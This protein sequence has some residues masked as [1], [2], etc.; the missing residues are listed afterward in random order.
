M[1]NLKK[2]LALVLALVM[3]FSLMATAN[4]FTDS[5]KINGT[6]EE[7][8]EVLSGLKVFQGYDNGSFV[9]Q[10]SITRAEVAAIIY[11]IVTGDV[12]DKQVGIYADYNKFND[13]KSTS[14]YAGYVNFCA[15]AEYIK[16]YDAKTFGP[17]DP[18]T[19]YQALAMIL[20]AVGYD[21]NGEFTGTGWQ[22]QT[23]AVGKKLGITNNV[24][25]GTLGVAATREV[26]AEILF[27]S[28]L[29]P[30]VEYTVAFGYQSIGQVSIGYETFKL[31][32]F[33]SGSDV[34]G[35]PAKVWKLDADNDRVAESTDVTLVSLAYEP[36]AT[37]TVKEDEC[38]IAKDLGISVATK[39]EKAFIDGVEYLTTDADVTTNRYGTINPLA[40]TSYVGAQG[41]L[42]EIYDMGTAGYRIVEINTYLA[43]VS[44]VVAE[45]V[46]KSGHV[47]PAYIG[48]NVYADS[49]PAAANDGTVYKTFNTTGFN[50]GDY[51]LVTMTGNA[52][53]NYVVRSVEAAPMGTAGALMGWTNGAGT[54]PDT[55]TIGATTLNDADK[56]DCNWRV[57]GNWVPALDTYGNV[58]GLVHPVTNYLVV[59]AIEWQHAGLYQGH[60]T[61]NV[62]LADGSRVENVT[63]ASVNGFA[64]T[65]AGDTFGNPVNATVSDNYVNNGN[66]RQ[67]DLYYNHIFTYTVNADGSYSIANNNHA[68]QIVGNI[69]DLANATVV[70]G[71]ATIS[72]ATNTVVATDNTVFLVKNL[73]GTN[74]GYTYTTYVGKNNVPSLTNADICVL[75]DAN[76]YATLVVVSNYE[77]AANTFLAYV[78]EPNQTG[79]TT[80]LGRAYQVYKIGE[81]TAT[82][83]YDVVA[84]NFWQYSNEHGTGLY[85]FTV[86]ANNQIVAMDIQVCDLHCTSSYTAYANWDRSAVKAGI[87]AG[88]F[89]TEGYNAVAVD[90]TKDNGYTV[91][92]NNTAIKDYVV[93]TDTKYFVVTKTGLNSTAIVTE[94]TTAD[95]TA[96]S[97]VL[98]NYTTLGNGNL[99][100]NM[101]YVLRV[102]AD[103]QNPNPNPVNASLT[104]TR[105]A[106][107]VFT[108]TLKQGTTAIAGA[109]TY[110]QVSL[111]G[112]AYSTPEEMAYVDGSYNDAAKTWQFSGTV[113]LV[114]SGNYTIRV[115]SVV[116]TQEIASTTYTIVQ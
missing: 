30:Q 69:R 98:V 99:V 113:N 41:R 107:N 100:A 4:A 26:V 27:R 58:I 21:K 68:A 6:Y 17:N 25:E 40:T 5:D 92:T 51:V 38:D 77:L 62:M 115:Y 35:R 52:A 10:G 90:L 57:G 1:R 79:F 9:P 45:T 18:V 81:T 111:N 13:V 14:W 104:L 43:Q 59:E 95:V 86:N 2:I 44:K 63:V 46:D 37:Y 15:N 97:V 88:S 112:G 54:N 109:K 78:T 56:F 67:G 89:Q 28:I 39:I 105:G 36:A 23:A 22:T 103:G 7:A 108:A 110:V 55:T 70:N 76:G 34:W 24:S 94:G 42:T 12:T 83:V 116:G 106:N 47:T 65:N 71:R 31:V 80:A 33:V 48:V 87:L 3:S 93:T 19:G 72:N 61:A 8:V 50:V 96:G 66:N 16:G 101:V 114:G 11:R 49:N 84:N 64:V 60:A 75:T 102:V 20:R 29:V 53:A 32:G 85:L 73:V 82:V 91:T 74:A